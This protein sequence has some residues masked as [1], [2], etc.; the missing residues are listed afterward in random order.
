[1]SLPH[2]V[3]VEFAAVAKHDFAYFA[4]VDEE[5]AEIQRRLRSSSGQGLRH[6][7]AWFSCVDFVVDL[8]ALAFNI[9][10]EWARLPLNV[11]NQIVV[12]GEFELGR[13]LDFNGQV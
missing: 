1:L 9:E 4:F 7:D 8:V 6:F 3:K 10:Y 11:A 5:F 2:E 13:E 12:V